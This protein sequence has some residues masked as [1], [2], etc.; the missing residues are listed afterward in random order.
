MLQWARAGW[1]YGSCNRRPGAGAYHG[2]GGGLPPAAGDSAG[3]VQRFDAASEPSNCLH[4][5]CRHPYVS[6]FLGQSGKFRQ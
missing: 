1:H 2:R 3:N 5:L 6:C 4:L